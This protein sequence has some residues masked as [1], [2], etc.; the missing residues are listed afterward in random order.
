MHFRRKAF[1]AGGWAL[2]ASVLISMPLFAQPEQPAPARP[3]AALEEV[4][5]TARRRE[6]S[7][8]TV[9]ISIAAFSQEELRQRSINSTQDL[10]MAVPGIF[11][12]G[13]GSRS[14]TLYAI[15]GQAK[16][17]VGQ[18]APGVITYFADVPLP[19]NASSVPQ[20][21]IGSVQVLKGPQGTLFGR[22]TTGGAILTYPQKPTHEF[23]GYVET[24]I[25]NYN[26]RAVEGAINVPLTDGV[27]LRFAGQTQKRDGYT[28]NIGQGHDL[29]QLDSESYRLSLLVEPSDYFSNLSIVDYHLNDSSTSAALVVKGVPFA[30]PGVGTFRFDLLADRQEALGPRKIDIN[31]PSTNENFEQFGFTNRTDFEFTGW[32]ITNIFGYRQNDVFVQSQIDG[33]NTVPLE[34]APGVIVPAPIRV[35][36]G[37]QHSQM[38]QFTEEL[39]IKGSALADRLEWLVGAFYLKSEPDGPMANATGFFAPT[40]QVYQFVEEESQAIFV[41]LSYDLD[42]VAPG[43]AANLGVRRTWD[44]S[45]VCSGTG[46]APTATGPT[47]ASFEEGD[48]GELANHS[49]LSSEFSATTWTVGLDWQVNDGVF[50]YVTSRKGYRA[51]GINAPRLGSAIAAY[52]TFDPEEII[53]YEVG[54]RTDWQIQDV[55]G[56]LNLALFHN[57]ATDV[58][59][60]GTGLQTTQVVPNCSEADGIVFIDGDCNPSNDPSQSVINLNVGDTEV[61]GADFEVTVMPIGNLTLSATGTYMDTK[62][63]QYDVPGPFTPFYPADE[64]PILYTPEKSGTLGARYDMALGNGLGDLG[65][66]ANL[67]YAGEIEMY[68]YTANSYSIT[69]LRADWSDV[70]GTRFDVAL[71]ARNVFDKE[72]VVAPGVLTPVSPFGSAIY[73]EPRMFGAELRYRFGSE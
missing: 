62:T 55:T 26:Y 11:L 45:S 58:Q 19:S 57:E 67:Y 60:S 36:E 42:A 52:Q 25:G 48:C 37:Q 59:V 15:R 16:P 28:E 64:I 46:E 1:R 17:S 66:S 49:D 32:G 2:P 31:T 34:V 73:N 69:N 72:A 71:F 38:R 30:F 21:D 41:N 44:E 5:V 68:G 65:L 43:L 54:L 50:A 6:E 56:R 9:P 40:S 13:S 23:G 7:L 47:T 20:Y 35:L 3:S 53:D 39:H 27:A 14:N 8:Q 22:N 12:T 24:G 33:I 18:G 4:V 70:M 51:G 10:Q 29:D 61:Q 63:T